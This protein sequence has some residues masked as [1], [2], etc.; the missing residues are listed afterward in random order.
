MKAMAKRIATR[1]ID[2]NDVIDM[3][4]LLQNSATSMMVKRSVRICCR[5][6]F[7]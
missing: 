5:E 1:N 6:V 2:I 3:P 4:R 7:Q